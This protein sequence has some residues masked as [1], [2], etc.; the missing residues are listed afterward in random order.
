MRLRP[1]TVTV[2]AIA[3][4]AAATGLAVVMV[5]IAQPDRVSLGAPVLRGRLIGAAA[6]VQQGGPD[7]CLAPYPSDCGPLTTTGVDTAVLSSDERN[8]YLMDWGHL[9]ALRRDPG[10][11]AIEQL[12]GPAGCLVSQPLP[13]PGCVEV[14]WG[15][16][17]SFVLSPDGGFGYLA[18][19]ALHALRRDP[20]TGALSPLTGPGSCVGPEPGCVAA[21][22]LF[23]WALAPD[24]RTLVITT[25]T[26]L[27]VLN[28]DPSTGRLSLRR[29]AGNCLTDPPRP[30]CSRLRGA[31]SNI[32][33]SND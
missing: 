27:R 2:T 18:A 12:A 13:E 7:G 9:V 19:D 30:G 17:A 20:S 15:N 16:F 10:S 31:G 4:L 3:V 21:P 6:L 22:A 28:R 29:G 5:P 24:G 23:Q 1:T 32:T 11:G 25:P 26:S 14:T 33:F 8:L